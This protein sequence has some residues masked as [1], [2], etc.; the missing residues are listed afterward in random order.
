M[1]P[2]VSVYEGSPA[3]ST[4]REDLFLV[5]PADSDT[6][7]LPDPSL[8]PA[9]THLSTPAAPSVAP[10]TSEARRNISPSVMVEPP[11]PHTQSE[12]GTADSVPK[13][14]VPSKEAE[15][16]TGSEKGAAAEESNGAE[17]VDQDVDVDVVGTT[18]DGASTPKRKS[19]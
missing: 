7:H 16:D 4:H 2:N 11:T 13:E 18:S 1:Q 8:P 14:L 19:R 6:A 3:S 9:P 5:P 17:G 10:D 15:S 12:D